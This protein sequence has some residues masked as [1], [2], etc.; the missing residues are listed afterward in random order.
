MRQSVSRS[1]VQSFSQCLQWG[2]TSDCQK[3]VVLNL[4]DQTS[5][6]HARQPSLGQNL[7][8]GFQLCQ[9]NGQTHVAP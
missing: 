3:F 9:K 4:T 7:K 5:M 6:K 8:V 2:L 1:V